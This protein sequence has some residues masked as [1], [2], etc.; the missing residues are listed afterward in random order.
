MEKVIGTEADEVPLIV[1][2][3]YIKV[4]HFRGDGRS[5]HIDDALALF[6]VNLPQAVA[7]HFESDEAGLRHE[8][9]SGYSHH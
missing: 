8:P 1:G 9:V 5:R 4:I 2:Q 6:V 7:K 3:A